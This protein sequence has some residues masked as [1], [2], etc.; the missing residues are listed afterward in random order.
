MDS[1]PTTDDAHARAQRLAIKR[2]ASMYVVWAGDGYAVADQLD[3]DTW[4]QGATV[5]AEVMSDGCT[6]PPD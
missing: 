6:V 1:S 4:W 3:L 5:I 2:E